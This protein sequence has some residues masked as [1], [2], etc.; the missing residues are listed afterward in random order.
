MAKL[1]RVHGIKARHKRRATTNSKHTLPVAPNRLEQKFETARPDQ[2][3]TVDITF[4]PT[5][6]G[7]L[8]LAVVMDL[9]TWMVVGW[10]M[11]DRMTKE[12]AINAVNIA[13]FRRRPRACSSTTQTVAVNTA[14]TTTRHCSTL[15]AWWR[16]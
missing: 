4:I 9:Y 13:W 16:R 11:S 12:L 5:A 8:Y 15:T 1:M 10:S 14:A 3:W 2:V 7:W 6:E